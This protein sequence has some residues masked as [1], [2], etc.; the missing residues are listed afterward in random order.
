[1]SNGWVKIGEASRF[2]GGSL[3]TLTEVSLP[4]TR[5]LCGSFLDFMYNLPSEAESTPA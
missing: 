5:S 1:M 4:K 3:S 2:R